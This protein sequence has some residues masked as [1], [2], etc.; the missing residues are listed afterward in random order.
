MKAEYIDTAFGRLILSYCYR[1]DDTEAEEIETALMAHAEKAAKWGIC[2]ACRNS[3]CHPDALDR[4]GN[5][6]HQ[7]AC[8][9]MLKPESCNTF[10]GFP[11]SEERVLNAN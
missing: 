3:I 5:I 7:R 10:Q 6:W 1:H 11:A 2:I 9:L 8:Q 4:I